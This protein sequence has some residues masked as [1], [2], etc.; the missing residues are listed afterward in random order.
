LS[1]AD[2]RNFS[3]IGAALPLETRNYVPAVVEA[4]AALGMKSDGG[5]REVQT[6]SSGNVQLVYAT[7]KN[8]TQLEPSL[9]NK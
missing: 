6:R 3:A 5:L 2:V 1:R 8:T 4:M 9:A 7:T